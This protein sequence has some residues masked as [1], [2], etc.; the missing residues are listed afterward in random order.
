MNERYTVVLL[1]DDGTGEMGFYD[2]QSFEGVKD[3]VGSAERAAIAVADHCKL[4]V[5]L[6]T[7]TPIFLMGDKDLLFFGDSN[8]C[9]YVHRTR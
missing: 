9:A 3:N 1:T 2:T 7:Y 8:R 4:D 6:H 5:L